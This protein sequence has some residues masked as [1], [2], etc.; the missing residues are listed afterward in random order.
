MASTNQ[1]SI[2]A[3]PGKQE[4]FITREFNAPKNLVYKA[5]TDPKLIVQW[6]GPRDMKMKIDHYDLKNGGGYRYLHTDPQG[7]E[8]A[9]R[10]VCHEVSPELIIQ[11]FEFEG[12]P[13]KGHVT[14]DTTRFEDLP[15]G[16]TK[17]VIHSVFQSVSDRDAMIKSGMEGGMNQSYQRLDELLEKGGVR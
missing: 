15:G 4:M 9:F 7:N 12:L 14:L 3:D 10:G 2:K 1:T 16:R 17:I 5:F 8:Y 6:L 13:E 11:T